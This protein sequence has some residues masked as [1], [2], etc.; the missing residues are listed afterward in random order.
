MILHN[1]FVNCAQ[2]E[3]K[4]ITMKKLFLFFAAAA[5]IAAVAM[6]AGCRQYPSDIEPYFLTDYIYLNKSSS[7]I[8]VHAFLSDDGYHGSADSL[9]VIPVEGTHTILNPR[10]WRISS[11]LIWQWYYPTDEDYVTV[12]NGEKTVTHRRT[13]KN[14]R[15]N[16]YNG[17]SYTPLLE[18]ETP[19]PTT[20]VLHVAVLYIFTDDFFEDGEP[21]EN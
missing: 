6:T 14:E 10:E 1:Y 2:V 15:N 20:P 17:F 9:F 8:T 4:L 5:G 18:F 3:P 7:E 11:P 19:H 13:G 12:S 16:L 21:I